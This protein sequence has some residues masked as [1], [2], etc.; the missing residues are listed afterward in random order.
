MCLNPSEIKLVKHA[1]R[2]AQGSLYPVT[3]PDGAT[4]RAEPVFR[5]WYLQ[6]FAVATRNRLD[7]RAPLVAFTKGLAE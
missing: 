7:D 3:V 6:A 4:A 5:R 2:A 1:S